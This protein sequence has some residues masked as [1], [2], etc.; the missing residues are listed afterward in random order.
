MR[1]S[2]IPGLSLATVLI[3]TACG[4]SGGGAPAS[5][6]TA[7]ARAT[8]LSELRLKRFQT[9]CADWLPD[10]ADALTEEYLQGY[11][12]LADAPCPVFVDVGLAEPGAP[13]PVGSP[14]E[15]ALDTPDRVSET[16]VQESGVD[17]ADIVKID[18]VGRLYVLSPGGLSIMAAFPPETL[19]AQA[20]VSLDLAAG[21]SGFD[22][23]ELFLDEAAG[24]AVVLGS[25]FADGRAYA[26]TVFVDVSNPQAPVETGRIEVEG[27]GL[28]ARR[29]GARVHRV[30]RYDVPRP[31]WLYDSGGA[32][33]DLRSDYFAAQA[34]SDAV[35]ADRIKQDVRSAI[36]DRLSDDGVTGLLPELAFQTAG[37]ARSATTLDCANLSAPEVTTGLGM[38]V[39]D[40]FD[41]DGS[42]RGTSAVIN[43]AYTVY[44]S[45]QNLYLAQSSF[46]W[47]FAPVQDEETVI[48]RLQL[49]DIGAAQYRGLGK[50][51]GS[52]LNRFA[53]SEHDGHLRV[54]T[55]ESAFAAG[56]DAS[57]NHLWVLDADGADLPT[58]ASVQGFAPGERIQGARFLGE[59]GF[60]VTFR[61]IDPLF[62]FDLRDPLAP[63]IASE[64]KI[65][66]FSSYLAP[67]GDDYLLTV[68]RD[69]TDEGLSGAVAVQLFDVRDLDN[70]T[71]LASLA[72]PVGESGYSYS[73]AEYD[74]R[75]F[76]YFSDR[77]DAPAPGTLSLPLISYGQSADTRFTGFLVIRVD[78][79]SERPLLETARIDH[80]QFLDE[81][82]LCDS[83]SFEAECRA[84]YAFSDPRRSLF[85]QRD[86]DIVL[87]TVSAVGVRADDALTPGAPLGALAFPTAEP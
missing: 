55:T 56:R 38:A 14:A 86:Q 33:A 13:V 58:V 26:V 87:Y 42:N 19:G 70:V 34:D 21:Q 54:A 83:I 49:S 81:R 40:S 16:N 6:P 17:E 62:A 71:Q 73:I 52:L 80:A 69:G 65:P 29:V 53:L 76:N 11:A 45:A 67:L 20:P 64:L 43:N 5:S 77:S 39:I 12:C 57:L 50:V 8:P 31:D 46:G 28:E 30:S 24:R 36:G 82:G 60:V 27:Y 74:A 78:P 68:G 23:G 10:V 79:A 4:G 84:A 3:L 48:Y 22:A 41:L 37:A 15:D 18:S 35:A 7:E 9:G 63:R 61:Q 32:L 85:A 44:A 75:A 66:G 72:A 47:F 25:R 2:L 59:R 1:S 51:A